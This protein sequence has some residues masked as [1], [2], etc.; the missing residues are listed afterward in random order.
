MVKYYSDWNLKCNL[1]K[2]K[3]L[4]FKKGGKLKKERWFM[5]AQTVEVVD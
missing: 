2:N 1:K 3:I 5:Y 4:S